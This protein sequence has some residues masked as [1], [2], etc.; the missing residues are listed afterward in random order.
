MAILIIPST[1]LRSISVTAKGSTLSKCQA[2][3]ILLPTLSP[4]GTVV[5]GVT[6][7]MPR[8][9][10][11]LTDLDPS[12][13]PSDH[14]GTT[15]ASEIDILD[16]IHSWVSSYDFC[17]L[18]ITMTKRNPGKEGF[19]WLTGYNLSSLNIRVGTQGGNLGEH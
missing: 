9:L 15:S 13:L 7:P 8:N 10:N 11:P 6:S 16:S 3:Y 4:H 14:P 1:Q 17:L 5:S 18:I 2:Y 12:F 19:I